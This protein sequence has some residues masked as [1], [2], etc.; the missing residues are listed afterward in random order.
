[1]AH[2]VVDGSLYMVSAEPRQLLEKSFVIG[3]F[4]TGTGATA[5]LDDIC[6]SDAITGRIICTDI[7]T[8]I[9]SQLGNS[10]ITFIGAIAM[11]SYNSL[12]YIIDSIGTLWSVNP[13]ATP[14]V[15]KTRVGTTSY[16]STST[17]LSS[18]RGGIY[19]TV[20]A[21]TQ[22]LCRIDLIGS[23]NCIQIGSQT[24]TNVKA[25]TGI[26]G[27]IYLA[28]S[29][30]LYRI[31]ITTGVAQ[32]LD[33]Q[34]EWQLVTDMT[35][36]NGYLYVMESD[37]TLWEASRTS[38]GSSRVVG[39]KGEW[40]STGVVALAAFS[41]RSLWYDVGVQFSYD[42][43][44][45][46]YTNGTTGNTNLTNTQITRAT[47][48]KIHANVTFTCF[49]SNPESIYLNLTIVNMVATIN[50]ASVPSNITAQQFEVANSIVVVQA[51]NGTVLHI[52]GHVNESTEA[53][54][55]KRS[56]ASLLNAYTGIRTDVVISTTEGAATVPFS[57]SSTSNGMIHEVDVTGSYQAQ[58]TMQYLPKSES[59]YRVRRSKYEFNH[60][61]PLAQSR[62][63][64]RSSD[65]NDMNDVNDNNNEITID[66]IDDCTTDITDGL[67]QTR[68]CYMNT[69]IL[70]D[71]KPLSDGMNEYNTT[72]QVGGNST[73]SFTLSTIVA[74]ACDNPSSNDYHL[75][76][77]DM[78]GYQ[79]LRIEFEPV[80][81]STASGY[82]SR[83][84]S[85]SIDD[86]RYSSYATQPLMR[87][88]LA[89]GDIGC[90][91]RM[92]CTRLL[93]EFMSS[94]LYDQH[95]TASLIHDLTFISKN[96]LSRLPSS[97]RFDTAAT[98]RTLL[99]ALVTHGSEAAQQALIHEFEN[100]VKHLNGR[101]HILL[102]FVHMKQ[103]S[104]IWEKPLKKAYLDGVST[105]ALSLGLLV[106]RTN[107]QPSRQFLMDQHTFIMKQLHPFGPSSPL[108]WES[109]PGTTDNDN[110]S[111]SGNTAMRFDPELE[112]RAEILTHSLANI[113]THSDW[114]WLHA[115]ASSPS[116]HLRLV[117]KQ[118][119]HRFGS[120]NPNVVI[121]I[122]TKLAFFEPTPTPNKPIII[123]DDQERYY[124][125]S[126]M[127]DG[128]NKKKLAQ[129][130]NDPHLGISLP[131][132][133]SANFKRSVGND[134]AGLTMEAQYSIL[135]GIDQYLT[136]E[137]TTNNF[138]KFN[139]HL[140]EQQL[141]IIDA[142]AV[143]DIRSFSNSIALVLGQGTRF[144]K[145][146]YKK[147][148]PCVCC[149]TVSFIVFP[150][151]R[152]CHNVTALTPVGHVLFRLHVC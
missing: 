67:I 85:S 65:G 41:D 10:S 7:V 77:H 45:L 47:P 11:T 89:Y 133:A 143:F 116:S 14:F 129:L 87:R 118:V 80:T 112:S 25:I 43:R 81:T 32:P 18:G 54:N 123:G 86:A 19:T 136:L 148:L 94:L 144:E 76:F 149:H 49:A 88:L 40:A 42:F 82:R 48:F 24:F 52:Y 145:T 15:T 27:S 124:G 35:N 53:I 108:E 68:T 115:V 22:R 99:S 152:C 70:G 150:Y 28:A 111:N 95:D 125:A 120:S 101:E 134:K 102:S 12:Y 114:S 122:A 38:Y 30:T 90:N 106:D 97:S 1:M 92:S 75:C 63:R 36:I 16:W 84:S 56:L 66:R 137:A 23:T 2:I 44:S 8:G 128:N 26:L 21:P 83:S 6:T 72:G 113:A 110:D 50:G 132:N 73:L 57:S 91:D 100:G 60:Y 78:H 62:I 33:A 4:T 147:E 39:L 96:G 46:S 69:A 29:G 126:I 146:I 79:R 131:F 58:Y 31:P 20:G 5:I 138:V 59:S 141:N 139:A 74:L 105:A 107:H 9:V 104:T 17:S 51:R 61:H 98:Y 37:G 103:P 117:C 135:A 142:W 119:L 140:F 64:G 121:S 127:S 55:F 151:C 13:Y 109:S 71:S 93:P 130:P 34:G 3:N